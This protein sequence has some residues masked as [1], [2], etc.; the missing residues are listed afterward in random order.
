MRVDSLSKRLNEI[1]K[2]FVDQ[3]SPFIQH[4]NVCFDLLMGMSFASRN[5]ETFTE[6]VKHVRVNV[7]IFTSVDYSSWVANYSL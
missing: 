1:T 2:N 7:Y 5:A 3:F 6:T 4:K